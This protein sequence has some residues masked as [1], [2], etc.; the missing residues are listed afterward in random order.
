MQMKKNK[1]NLAVQGGMLALLAAWGPQAL[2]QQNSITGEWRKDQ[3]KPRLYSQEARVDGFVLQLPLG[4]TFAPQMT[5][6]DEN[7]GDLSGRIKQLSGVNTQQVGSYLAKY[8][9]RDNGLP[10]G[11]G[12][13]GMNA[14]T[15]TFSL[16]VTVYDPAVAVPSE[17]NKLGSLWQE[18]PATTG[19]LRF[20][21]GQ[22]LSRTI[23]IASTEHPLTGDELEITTFKVQEGIWGGSNRQFS[24]RLIDIESGESA[25]EGSVLLVSGK[26]LTLPAPIKVR[27]DRDYE[28]ILTYLTGQYEQG[29][30]ANEEGELWLMADG[31]QSREANPYALVLPDP[32][33]LLAFDPGFNS[34]LKQKLLSS[35]GE[36]E[37]LLIAKVP[38]P[39]PVALSY[40]IANPE[41]VSLQLVPGA[42]QDRLVLQG[43]AEGETTLEI[44]ADNRQVD[45]VRL[46]VTAPKAV[47]LSYSYIAFPGERQSHLWD[48]GAIIMA[49]MSRRFA[50]YNIRLSWV[51]NGILVHEWDKN[52]D[53]QAY[54]P[55]TVELT[56][57]LREGWIPNS[58]QV[59]SNIYVL[60]G[61]KDDS[62]TCSYQGNGLSVGL[63]AKDG[64]PR[65]GYRY[66]CPG[67]VTVH[68]QSLTLSHELGH[69]LGLSH[70]GDEPY[71]MSNIM[72][73]GR[74]EGVFFGYQ[75]RIMHQT[76]EARIAAG[77]AGVSEVG[78]E[79]EPPQPAINQPP[80]A[81]AGGDMRTTGPA[82]LVLDGAASR[83]PEN[84]T[85]RYQWRQVGGPQAS[86]RDAEQARARLS[87]GTVSQDT[88]LTFELTVTDEQGLAGAD[89]MVVTHQ[90][91]P[92]NQPPVLTALAPASV[93][94][95][96]Q[97][98]FTASATD[99]DGDA[100]SYQWTV[101][102]G[103][104]ASGQSSKTLV[105]TAPSVAVNTDYDLTVTV[106]DGALDVQGQT[107]LTV[108]PAS[109]GGECNATD[110]DAASW[111]AWSA[112]TVYNADTKVSHNQLVWQAKY[113]TQGNEPSQAADQW[114]LVSQVQL[115]WNAGVAYSGGD[116]TT[117]NGRKWQ[118]QYWTRGNEP[119]KH[120]VWLDQGAANCN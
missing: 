111:P 98:S 47:S 55:S 90:A 83:D 7:D 66:A 16:P 18:S 93:Q 107:R 30:R 68:G 11:N 97:V 64:A 17:L 33:N 3:I 73:G 103:L 10:G 20:L 36:K 115:G 91:P 26:Q 74:L 65:A 60:R 86:L 39:Q 14:G 69:N 48:D 67:N 79:P 84:G 45:Q 114:K 75:W 96:M 49:D 41:L 100:L 22:S 2:A 42:T 101:P 19:L 120:D 81:N 13:L 89:R 70:T 82:E 76:L 61:Y 25:Y 108:T 99:P 85:L 109:G 28:F 56:A 62:R 51:D 27:A 113:W 94:A 63:G 12:Y 110:P 58:E 77:D 46:F 95:G 119:G 50:P 102:A 105:L 9:V 23:R 32:A 53:G 21:P 106:T 116:V 104:T 117:H 54:E 6:W 59:F 112:S 35:R 24:L 80:L 29:F 38:G 34:A 88:Q 72:T 43:L 118:A 5:A 40:R 87:L 57:P 4:A 78:A 71:R 52:G 8:E 44:L 1:V 31:Q 15:T 92:P 37:A